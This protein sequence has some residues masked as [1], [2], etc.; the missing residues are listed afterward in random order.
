[1]LPIARNHETAK[2]GE[3]SGMPGGTRSGTAER[4]KER[5]IDGMEAQPEQT[6]RLPECIEVPAQ[7]RPLGVN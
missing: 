3:Q 4:C 7:C 1:M 2:K 5:V 6:C